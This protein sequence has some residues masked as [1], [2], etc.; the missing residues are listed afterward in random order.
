MQKQDLKNTGELHY[1]TKLL[2]V[3]KCS[4]IGTIY[5]FFCSTM[6]V[7]DKHPVKIQILMLVKTIKAYCLIELYVYLH[8]IVELMLNKNTKSSKEGCLLQI[9]IWLIFC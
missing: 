2:Q 8:R 3:S 1:L 4:L 9:Y 5:I 6:Y 7:I